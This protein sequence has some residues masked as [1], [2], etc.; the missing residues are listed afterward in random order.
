MLYNTSSLPGMVTYSVVPTVNGCGGAPAN[1]NVTVNPGVVVN[2]VNP[3]TVCS[4]EKSAEVV[5]GANT[6]NVSFNWTATAGAY[7]TGYTA[8]GTG[9][10]PSE[11]VTNTGSNI[12]SVVYTIS[13]NAAGCTGNN[14]NYIFRVNPVPHT[15]LPGNQAICSGSQSSPVNLTANVNGAVFSWT[16]SASSKLSG[17]AASGTGEIPSQVIINSGTDDDSVVYT[18]AATANNCSG[19]NKYYVIRVHP[20][21]QVNVTPATASICSGN[22]TSISLSSG[23]AGTNFNWVVNAP[24][25]ISGTAD[26]NG[27]SIIQTL[28]SSGSSPETVTYIISPAGVAC[29][30]NPDSL[31][32]VVNPGINIQLSTGPQ[33]ICSGQSTRQF[34]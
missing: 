13:A 20:N 21:A 7:L 19:P 16:A 28:N 8:Q 26:G 31:F 15:I 30:G 11:T 2:P 4:G 25:D 6:S 12:D 27:N 22:Q 29:P 23:V 33:N 1:Y 3:Q 10:I 34:L 24:A 5:L 18:I 17:Y 14:V 32:I 9:N